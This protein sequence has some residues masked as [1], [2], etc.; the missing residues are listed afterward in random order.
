MSGRTDFIRTNL[1]E[2]TNSMDQT[3]HH[4]SDASFPICFTHASRS[5][6]QE[7]RVDADRVHQVLEAVGRSDGSSEETNC[8]VTKDHVD[9]ETSEAQINGTDCQII[10]SEP[11]HDEE[12]MDVTKRYRTS[13]S[14]QQIKVLEKIYV[15]E[16]YISRPQRSKL[17]TELNLPE[18]TIKVWFQNRRMKEKRQSM[19]LPTIAGKDPYLRETL[20]RVTQL[21]YATRYGATHTDC[22]S[23]GL[24]LDPMQA[25]SYWPEYKMFPNSMTDQTSVGMNLSKKQTVSRVRTSTNRIRK[26]NLEKLEMLHDFDQKNCGESEPGGTTSAIVNDLLLSSTKESRLFDVSPSKRCGNET[27]SVYCHAA[28]E[29][30]QDLTK[31]TCY[32]SPQFD[33]YHGSNIRINV[34]NQQKPYSPPSQNGLAVGSRMSVDKSRFSSFGDTLGFTPGVD[35]PVIDFTKHSTT[36]QHNISND[37]MT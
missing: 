22:M 19:M 24:S 6:T 36:N 7:S 2:N 4:L 35:F 14:Q 9:Y 18:N 3:G 25:V 21:Y 10:N 1:T 31:R 5:L 34:N 37:T 28:A 33:Y 11:Q 30:V 32:H 12:T 17:A 23:T 29:E 27:G 26:P 15:T 20:L 16:R 13:Y 8:E